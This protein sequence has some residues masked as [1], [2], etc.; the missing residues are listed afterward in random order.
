MFEDLFGGSSIGD[1]KK[2][3]SGNLFEGIFEPSQVGSNLLSPSKEDKN[4]LEKTVGVL[5]KIPLVNMFVPTFS[6]KEKEQMA[7][8]KVTPQSTS[9]PA[10]F[11]AN[12]KEY[13]IPNYVNP[14]TLDKSIQPKLEAPKA[15]SESPAWKA[16]QQ[17]K[18]NEA[19]VLQQKIDAAKVKPEEYFIRGTTFGYGGDA[20]F[21]NQ[22]PA[23]TPSQKGM[24]LVGTLVGYSILG[25]YL[26]GS[27]GIVTSKIPGA[28]KAIATANNLMQKNVIT[29][30]INPIKVAEAFG[31]G[32]TGG[33]ITKAENIKDRVN[34]A[35]KGGLTFAAFD[36][37]LQPVTSFLRPS[38]ES[39]GTET[40]FGI[41]KQ[42]RDL[43]PGADLDAVF[44]PKEEI[45]ASHPTNP[46]LVMK[47]TKQTIDAVPAGE[48]PGSPN[49]FPVF[50]K[51]EVETFK[52]NPSLYQY[53]K[54]WLSNKP[55]SFSMETNSVISEGIKQ[56]PTMTV[57]P[58]IAETITMPGVP[59]NPDVQ[60]KI[61]MNIR[62]YQRGGGY[63][64]VG[65]PNEDPM[66]RDLNALAQTPEGK[67]LSEKAINEAIASGKLPVD[68][69]GK[70]TVYRVGKTSPLNELT[71]VTFNEE[72]AKS[73]DRT[74][75]API[76]KFQVTP[77]EIS[78]FIGGPEYEL[79]LKRQVV[80]PETA[81]AKHLKAT[82]T[83]AE[84]YA[85]NIERK[86]SG[87]ERITKSPKG[88]E[89]L[90][91]RLAKEEVAAKAIA[92]KTELK[93]QVDDLYNS[94]F[95]KPNTDYQAND[96][97]NTILGKEKPAFKLEKQTGPT[98]ADLT[99]EIDRWVEK[100]RKQADLMASRE[101]AGV[102][103]YKS[104]MTGG[105]MRVYNS[106]KKGRA[107]ADMKKRSEDSKKYAEDLLYE[108][109]PEFRDL[110]DKRDKQ[111]ENSI[112]TP[113]DELSP[114]YLDAILG[115]VSNE[116]IQ[117]NETINQFKEPSGEVKK[118]EGKGTGKNEAKR[119]E[120]TRGGS[121]GGIEE[122]KT[123]KITQKII[124][125]KTDEGA[126]FVLQTIDSNGKV[127]SKQNFSTRAEAESEMTP[128]PETV[129]YEGQDIPVIGS[130]DSATGKITL[131]KEAHGKMETFNNGEKVEKNKIYKSVEE[132]KKD[133]TNEGQKS[134]FDTPGTQ[135]DYVISKL[136]KNEQVEP[137]LNYLL[138]ELVKEGLMD[139]VAPG[140]G[141]K[142]D[143]TG[144]FYK[145]EANADQPDI[146]D[147]KLNADEE[148]GGLGSAAL[149]EF[150]N[151]E[152]VKGKAPDELQQG[153][154][155]KSDFKKGDAV[156]SSE[157]EKLEKNKKGVEKRVP[158]DGIVED[159]FDDGRA[160]VKTEKGL[161]NL[162]YHKLSPAPSEKVVNKGTLFSDRNTGNPIPKEKAIEILKKLFPEKEVEVLTQKELMV[163]DNG[164][165]AFGSSME[166]LIKLVESN[167]KIGDKVV[168][169]EAFH[170]YLEKFTS[171]EDK[172]AVLEGTTEEKLADDFAD[173]AAGKDTFLDK[174]K[175]LFEKML[176]HIKKWI[177]GKKQIETLFD[178]ILQG[179]RPKMSTEGVTRA[180]EKFKESKNLT[181]AQEKA[182][183][184]MREIMNDLIAGRINETQAVEQLRAQEEII[185]GAPG[186]KELY[187]EISDMD[188]LSDDEINVFNVIQ[189]G[190]PISEGLKPAVD[191]LK[192]KGFLNKDYVPNISITKGSKTPRP[193]A[194]PF[195]PGERISQRGVTLSRSRQDITQPYMLSYKVSDKRV[196]KS[197]NKIDDVK[198]IYDAMVR[199]R[200]KNAMRRGELPRELQ[201]TDQQKAIIHMILDKKKISEIQYKRLAL[202]YTGVDSTLKMTPEQAGVLINN[203]KALKPKFGGKVIVPNTKTLVLQ[204]TAERVFKSKTFSWLIDIFRSPAN[205]FR[206]IGIEPET[207]HVFE[208]MKL[209]RDFVN[210]TF[211]IFSKWQKEMGITTFKH[212][213]AKKQ[214]KEQSARMFNAMNTGNMNGLSEKESQV[215]ARA[216]DLASTVADNVDEARKS[217]GLPPMNRRANYITNLL[218]DEGHFLIST[219][220]QAP[221]ELYAIMDMR[222][223]SK[224]FDRLL[225]ERK[226]GLPIKQDFWLA[227]KAMTQ[228]HAKYIYLNPPVH[229]LAQFMKF[230]GDNVPFL[231][232]KYVQN[233]IGRFLNRPTVI[234]SWLLGL[235][236]SMTKFL[237]KLPFMSRKF[238]IEL[239]SGV[240]EILDIPRV[241]LKIA[242]GAIP[243][244]KSVRYMYDLTWSIS[245]YATNLTQFWVNTVP[246]LRGTPLDVYRSAITGYA[247]MMVDF[248]R[249]SKWEYWRQR[250]V[251]T[252]MDNVI[253]NEYRAKLGGNV[254]N[255]FAKL[256]EFNNRVAS[257]IATE[258]NIK[259]LQKKGKADLLYKE[260]NKRYG[261]EIQEY[262]RNLA[263][264]TQFK[265][266]VETKPIF[267]DNPIADLYYQYNTFA[268]K[269]AELVGGM[270]KSTRLLS[271]IKD[272]QK[273][274]AEGTTK[275]FLTELTQGERAEFIR[276]L[277]NAFILSFVLGS[278]YVFTSVFKGMIPNQVQGLSDVM[279]GLWTGDK[280]K[281]Q[282]GYKEILKP[283]GYQLIENLAVYG[284]KPVLMHAKAIRQ[285][286]L[287]YSVVTGK[288]VGLEN[289][290]GKVTEK[291]GPDVALGR[292]V[293]SSKEKTAVA[294]SKG[295]DTYNAINSRY[296][297]NRTE[298]LKLIAEGKK[299][300]A[301]I[302]VKKYNAQA[303]KDIAE[304]KRLG[305]TDLRLQ[306]I[307][308]KVDKSH[309][310]STADFNRWIK[311]S[312]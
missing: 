216:I 143:V 118:I 223:P 96:I 123:G 305:I 159:I 14:A 44:K 26:K 204:E 231:S 238:E 163:S 183:A 127:T 213:T 247:Q 45:W 88:R 164:K 87:Q 160:L 74:G 54:N 37:V 268:I 4:F 19:A 232:R 151:I 131:D 158:G 294:N 121:S 257:A 156:K 15:Q 81:L 219:T 260:L 155:V 3:T 38:Y 189:K 147:Y 63:S 178:D 23:V 106:F 224:V 237:G 166:N 276:F 17:S 70:I 133:M 281:L 261:S 301:K 82:M 16:W 83:P 277:M 62:E 33:F 312:K 85:K 150:Y 212:L 258:K 222:L 110:V 215:V 102:R 193:A 206:S 78:Y 140:E 41:N 92:R 11:T 77:Q 303:K 9:T 311:E 98:P 302:L 221:N 290:S 262:A 59:R 207:A 161:Q 203:L 270:M 109:D 264:L 171:A 31:L 304:F 115:E 5:D 141:V 278:G 188:P 230:Y 182:A 173:Y 186:S 199:L 146:L 149:S 291:I 286:E 255:I 28:E 50:G 137:E 67:K 197:F 284:I 228:M 148:N 227:M 34:N 243:T 220:K 202:A 200:S 169:H 6:A 64:G 259:I 48:A 144:L 43:L 42:M 233:R 65:K 180:L 72:F 124:T 22:A 306:D 117:A 280:D 75:N 299:S 138:V 84:Y 274:H 241:N 69:K 126:N 170:Q 134:V 218:T 235:D 97:V 185:K 287:I 271:V 130:I 55:A 296:A 99:K 25:E 285:A 108:N 139:P 128:M 181:P 300:Q 208:G 10:K 275:E 273:A 210:H 211:G 21:N 94:L 113:I 71:S 292:L 100:F 112:E 129:Q 196:V 58:D 51:I 132:A 175:K 214:I 297:N 174:V 167:G 119:D 283:P 288:K 249:P 209:R 239:Q 60:S 154:G 153:F 194:R 176:A 307:I 52:R 177:T 267:F 195:Q 2:K 190:Q 136:I 35:L 107:G 289:L 135:L 246:K 272:Y 145:S 192:A 251:L 86:L 27:L 187:K 53:L 30:T 12:G 89:M 120:G 105:E 49:S 157:I 295:W 39:L 254:L 245:F 225:L 32:G 229:R 56:K 252:E 111:L 46:N 236:E 234:E 95:L 122:V 269:Q 142:V 256:S 7:P 165:I 168:Y 20:G 184:E 191:S 266:G 66:L 61:D 279:V 116:I 282:T 8:L 103:Q 24:E 205:V 47:I 244:L 250:G 253:D 13:T 265:Y 104:D 172:A 217:I 310:V 240:K 152:A 91:E 90:A 309:I 198:W 79:L 18:Q 201:P 36:I 29:R 242:Q 93:K 101:G 248:L 263:D 40:K 308:K 125:E 179:K 114:E 73:F 298:A 226:G 68:S 162:D 293:A 80:N 76:K 1:P 57:E